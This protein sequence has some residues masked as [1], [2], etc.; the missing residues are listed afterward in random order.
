MGVS[1]G[2][3]GL[4]G[5]GCFRLDSRLTRLSGSRLRTLLS[6]DSFDSTYRRGYAVSLNR[7]RVFM[8]HVPVAGARCGGLFSAR[9]LCNLPACFGCNV[10][11]TKLK[12]FQRLV[13]RFGAAR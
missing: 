13:A 3:L 7:F 5:R 4:E 8:G 10:N 12:T 6:G 9:G 2:I 11:S 1:G